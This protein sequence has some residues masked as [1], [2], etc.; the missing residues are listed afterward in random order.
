L[1]TAPK[2]GDT[3]IRRYDQTYQ[4][5]FQTHFQTPMAQDKQWDSV[6][7]E[8][9]GLGFAREPRSKLPA[10]DFSIRRN[11]FFKK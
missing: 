8:G 1:A 9:K 10:I 3:A 11:L 4:T 6:G 5:R 7:T 2:F